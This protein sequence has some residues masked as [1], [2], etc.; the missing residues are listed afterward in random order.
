MADH[1]AAG[2]ERSIERA[3][4]IVAGKGR[5][6]ASGYIVVCVADQNDLAV[7][8]DSHRIGKVVPAP[9]GC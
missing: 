4:T 5:E 6:G 1:L 8:L 7:R 2:T 3:V 9:H